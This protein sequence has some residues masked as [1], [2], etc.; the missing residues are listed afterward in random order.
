MCLN[1]C[2]RNSNNRCLARA[3]SVRIGNIIDQAARRC[4]VGTKY[5]IGQQICAACGRACTGAT[6]FD[7]NARII[8]RCQRRVVDDGNHCTAQ[9]GGVDILHFIRNI[10]QAQRRSGLVQWRKQGCG[11]GLGR[12]RRIRRVVD[13]KREDRR[14]RSASRGSQRM[15]TI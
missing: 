6:F 2:A 15:P 9:N 12:T 10:Q 4:A 5:I 1:N 3:A 7:G 13:H 11:H 8:N 14:P